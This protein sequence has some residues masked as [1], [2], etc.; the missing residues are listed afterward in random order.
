MTFGSIEERLVNLWTFR[1][2]LP[3]YKQ[4]ER[5]TRQDTTS[6][7]DQYEYVD[8]EIT[9][10]KHPL[11]GIKIILIEVTT[12]NTT[13]SPPRHDQYLYSAAAFKRSDWLP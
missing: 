4:E 8:V 9:P 10:S 3:V 5:K 13:S 6:L 2:S 7:D 12:I 11:V 1:S